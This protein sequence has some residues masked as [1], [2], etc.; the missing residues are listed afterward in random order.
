MPFLRTH[1]ARLATLSVVSISLIIMGVF[2]IIY[3]GLLGWIGAVIATAFLLMLCIVF[4]ILGFALNNEI[5]EMEDSKY[6]YRLAIPTLGTI[7]QKGEY[8]PGD[9]IVLLAGDYT[10][11]DEGVEK[12]Q[13]FVVC[14][15]RPKDFNISTGYVYR[16]S[17]TK[18]RFILRPNTDLLCPQIENKFFL[19]GTIIESSENKLET[20]VDPHRHDS[21]TMILA[22]Q[23][24]MLSQKTE[25]LTAIAKRS[26]DEWKRDHDIL[27]EVAHTSITRAAR[28][29][30]DSNIGF[31]DGTTTEIQKLKASRGLAES[32]MKDIKNELK[33]VTETV[34]TLKKQQI[35][36]K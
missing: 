19:N 22:L 30:E 18:K 11:V 25:D 21:K 33:K 34:E 32:N 26:Y 10:F 27:Y 20:Y 31:G 15:S 35:Y 4:A 1:N 12:P 13:S 2:S 7:P 5:N 28:L 14:D 16:A 6:K 24:K 8:T 29:K 9:P 23:V 17:P 36:A 3:Y